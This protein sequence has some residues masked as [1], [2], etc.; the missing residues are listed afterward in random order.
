[1]RRALGEGMFL[2]LRAVRKDG[3]YPNSALKYTLSD[4]FASERLAFDRARLSKW[5]YS[6]LVF[7]SATLCAD[8]Q[9]AFSI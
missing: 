6:S 4:T 8:M 9:E 2:C 7:F 5:G 3:A 1:M